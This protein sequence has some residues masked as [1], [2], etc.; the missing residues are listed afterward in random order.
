MF[1]SVCVYIYVQGWL[2]ACGVMKCLQGPAVVAGRHHRLPYV[3]RCACVGERVTGRVS[4]WAGM[5]LFVVGNTAPLLLLG[6]TAH[7]QG[8]R[9]QH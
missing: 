8:C 4:G 6:C 1:I 5:V 9:Q 2:W 7:A 3:C